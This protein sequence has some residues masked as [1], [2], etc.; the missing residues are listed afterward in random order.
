LGFAAY[1]GTGKTTLLKKV[2]PLL[3]LRG[4]RI[5]MIKH[6]HHRFEVDTQGKDS[7]E[8]RKA[9]AQQMLIASPSRQAMIIDKPQESEPEL[10]SL[11]AEF[12]PTELDLILVEG[13]RHEAFDK[14]ELH[15]SETGKPLLFPNDPHIIALAADAALQVDTDLPR[16][17]INDAEQ[18]TQFILEYIS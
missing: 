17:N 12:N 6:S 18:L 1:S 9:G 5:G 3:K 11:L 16:L 13:F 7:Y 4:L 8:L 15:R 10:Q 14:I 2:L